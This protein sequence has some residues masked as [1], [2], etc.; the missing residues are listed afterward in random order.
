MEFTLILEMPEAEQ[1]AVWLRNRIHED[2]FPNITA[3][4]LK[5]PMKEGEMSGEMLTNILLIAATTSVVEGIKALIS[6]LFE[7]FKGKRAKLELSGTCPD[8][9]RQLNLSFD[10][11]SSKARDL[12]LAEFERA[13]S[14]LCSSETS[15]TPIAK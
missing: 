1:E 2:D 6:Y 13:F 11:S 14:V 10:T 12:A 3:E 7:H 15:S 9:G 8:N 4:V 5:T